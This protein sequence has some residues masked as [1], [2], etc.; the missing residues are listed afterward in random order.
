MRTTAE[1]YARLV[2]GAAAA[3][4]SLPR[5]LIESALRRSTGG[6]SL[7]EQ[8][9]WAERLDVVETRLIRIG[10]NLNQMAA[11]ANTTG[12]LPDVLTGAVRY[13]QATLD[14]HRE[15]LKAIDPADRSRR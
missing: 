3:R 2:V 14:Q 13:L 10:T 4:L 9:W 7:R 8:R 12:E 6:W 1:T 11:A 5:Y 15:I